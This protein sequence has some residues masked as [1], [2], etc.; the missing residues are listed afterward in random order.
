M[1][2]DVGLLFFQGADGPPRP[3]FGWPAPMAEPIASLSS[4]I[5]CAPLAVEIFLFSWNAV[6][7]RHRV[8]PSW[9]LYSK[10]RSL[11]L[12]L[13][14]VNVALRMPAVAFLAGSES[15]RWR[16]PQRSSSSIAELESIHTTE[17]DSTLSDSD[18]EILW[19]Q[20]L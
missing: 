8:C 4:P 18:S 5:I 16:S 12:M 13:K 9:I 2:R 17:V 20:S 1:Y 7:L 3:L 14:A 10:Q 15:D 6:V 19:V 11:L